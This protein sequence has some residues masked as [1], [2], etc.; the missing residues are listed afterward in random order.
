MQNII[1]YNGFNLLVDIL[2][3][4]AV[5]YI[6]ARHYYLRGY[7]AG[8]NDYRDYAEKHADYY[9]DSFFDQEVD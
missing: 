3:A 4:F 7:S 9:K 5:F 1:F 8:E 2:I 6:T